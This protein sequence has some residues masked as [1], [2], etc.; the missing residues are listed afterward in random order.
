[1][2]GGYFADPGIKDVPSLAQCGYP[3]AE[4]AADGSATITKLPDTGGRV[5]EATVKEQLMYEVHDP[6]A[7]LTPDVTADFSQVRIQADGDDRVR[8]SHASGR[9]RPKQLKVTVGFDAGFLAEAGVSYAGPA[10]GARGRQARDI[11]IERLTKILDP[12]SSLRVDL[13]GASSLFA[14]A[15]HADFEG[16]DVRLHAA[17]RTTSRDE[18]EL[19]L[20]EVESLLCCGPAGGGGFRGAITAAV[21]T[22][23]VLIDRQLTKPT[24]E[25]FV[26]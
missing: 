20:W 9:Q 3:I 7:Y 14:T 21:M 6:A 25:M 5:S 19:M 4:V 15:G 23:S 24:V 22:K 11:V 8:V 12:Q 13:I 2:T 16:E 26:A 17:L 10:A 18:A 1:V